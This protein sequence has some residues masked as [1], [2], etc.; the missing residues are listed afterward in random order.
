MVRRFDPA[1]IL[2]FSASCRIVFLV[3]GKKHGRISF[4]LRKSWLKGNPDQTICSWSRSI[5]A[6]R[7]VGHIDRWPIPLLTAILTSITRLRL[8]SGVEGTIS[9][10][11]WEDIEP[12]I[13]VSLCIC[14][15]VCAFR[16]RKLEEQITRTRQRG[17]LAETT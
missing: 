6:A 10:I 14:F 13:A 4:D 7:Q 11:K 12:I 2:T 16:R 17:L 15:S 3:M 9:G 5:P 8:S 1:G